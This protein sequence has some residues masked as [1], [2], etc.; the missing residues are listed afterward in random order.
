[1]ATEELDIRSMIKDAKQVGNV[2]S[3]RIYGLE[4]IYITL[5]KDV[6]LP[7]GS[8]V[9]VKDDDG[10]PIVYQVTSPTYYRYSFDFEKR[11]IAHG[12][13]SRDE[14]HTYDCVGIL[15]GKVIEVI[16]KEDEKEEKRIEIQPPRYPVPPLSEVYECTSDLM[17]VLTKPSSEPVVEI[18]EE[19]LTGLRVRIALRAL[20][21]QGL[22]ISG[23]QG[24][25]K[26]TALLTLIYRSLEAF[27]RLRFLVLD[28]TGEMEV[29]GQL[30]GKQF[31]NSPRT[32]SVKVLSWDRMINLVYTEPELL[33]K[34]IRED[35]PRVRRAVEEVL[36]DALVICA[37]EKKFP[38]KEALEGIVKNEIKGR[39]QET[40]ETVKDVISRSKWIPDEAVEE[41]LPE[42][43]INRFINEL[44]SVNI[45]VVDFSKT[46]NP[47]IPDEF[48]FKKMIAEVMAWHVWNT[49]RVRKDFGCV[50]VSDEAHRICP[51]RGYGELASIWLRLATEGGRNGCPLWLVAR[52]LSLVSKSVT[53]ELQQ[54]FFCFNVEDVDRRRVSEDLGETFASLLGSLPPGEAIVKSAA[55][56]RV[57]GQVIHVC[58][59]QVLKPSSAEYGLEERFP[60]RGVEEAEGAEKASK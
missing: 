47:E 25:G 22:L 37:K 30:H 43:I 23:A 44:E 13:I 4:K 1:L 17:E 54:N 26:T 28:W 8:Y 3:W 40:I 14:A 38:T 41:G 55:G 50:V 16:K 52:R 46:E 31:G 19:P 2:F 57:P 35:D 56:F 36:N 39:R 53:T 24:T 5:R 33:F 7:V 48:E 32:I 9:F 29:L 11:L 60:E 42:N 58:F 18:G 27:P 15:I 21:R 6:K 20:I 10:L 12:G 51:E 59:D 49:A 45:Y 34:L